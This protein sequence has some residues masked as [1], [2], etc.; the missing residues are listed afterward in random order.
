MSPK[1]STSNFSVRAEWFDNLVATLKL[2]QLQ[3]NNHD[4]RKQ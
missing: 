2:H 4:K 3:N 1:A